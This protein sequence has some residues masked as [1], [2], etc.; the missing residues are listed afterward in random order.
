MKKLKSQHYILLFVSILTVCVAAISYNFLYHQALSKAEAA[1]VAEAKVASMAAT[2]I[3]EKKTAEIFATTATERSQLSDSMVSEGNA[4]PFIDSVEG[5]AAKSGA[6]ISLSSLSS[7]TDS[8]SSH[9]T[10]LASVTIR[11]SWQNA[12]RALELLENLPYAISMQNLNLTETNSSDA[13]SAPQWTINVS[14]SVLSIP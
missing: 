9:A 13:K 2:S 4:V 6:T 11:G 8:A 3:E 14:L 5:I 7:G 12:L 1:A 10:V